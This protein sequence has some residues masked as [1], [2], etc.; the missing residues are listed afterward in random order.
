[1]AIVRAPLCKKLK[2]AWQTQHAN[3]NGHSY[4]TRLTFAR[5]PTLSLIT[6]NRPVL[7]IIDD[8]VA[9]RKCVYLLAY[10]FDRSLT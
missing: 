1:M 4:P 2:L 10:V 8:R 3:N 5:K 7:A 6:A 9:G